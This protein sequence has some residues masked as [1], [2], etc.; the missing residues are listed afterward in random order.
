MSW[1]RCQSHRY[2]PCVRLRPHS[3]GCPDPNPKEIPLLR[4]LPSKEGI[5]FMRNPFKR[6][7]G[8]RRE[9]SSLS[10]LALPWCVS[11]RENPVRPCPSPLSS[12][13][14][15]VQ[16]LAPAPASTSTPLLNTLFFVP[17][18]HGFFDARCYRTKVWDG[19]RQ[20]FCMNTQ[21]CVYSTH[22]EKHAFLRQFYLVQRWGMH[23][24]HTMHG[25][26]ACRIPTFA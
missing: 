24:A 1:P 22:F 14:A 25:L 2:R 8:F 3:S 12:Q 4:F 18:F 17:G 16:D 21:T 5:S 7:C 11:R 19:T 9:S 10:P 26:A 6:I 15:L 23:N 20:N 13:F